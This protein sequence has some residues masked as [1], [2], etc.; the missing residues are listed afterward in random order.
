MVITKKGQ[1][2]QERGYGIHDVQCLLQKQMLSTPQ[3]KKRSVPSI[4]SGH[5]QVRS[6]LGSQHH[7][8][9]NHTGVRNSYVDL[10][11]IGCE[12]SKATLVV[13]G[14]LGHT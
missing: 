1:G 10:Y 12:C 13:H 11:G 8:F 7:V 4:C 14:S 2:L 6:H 3:S 5:L 9:G